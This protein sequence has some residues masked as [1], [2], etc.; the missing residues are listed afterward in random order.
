VRGVRAG[1]F[2]ERQRRRS[3]FIY[4]WAAAAALVVGFVLF[5]RVREQQ[6][7]AATM[8]APAISYAQQ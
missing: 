2:G 8:A 4:V 3:T 1:A 5:S 6:N 7:T